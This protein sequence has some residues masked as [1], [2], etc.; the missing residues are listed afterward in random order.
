MYAAKVIL[1]AA[2]AALAALA[3][4]CTISGMPVSPYGREAT[5][6]GQRDRVTG[7]LIALTPD[8]IWLLSGQAVQPHTGRFQRID[9]RRHNFGLRRTMT[10]LGWAGAGTGT[11]LMIA[12]NSYESSAEGSGDGDCAA[13][14][15]GT[16]L[17]FA[18]A[19]VIFGSINEYTSRHRLRA[20]DTLRLRAFT[21][22]PQGLPDSLRMLRA[23]SA[24]T[25]RH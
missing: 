5:L 24:P 1:I 6:V 7:E 23:A 2:L 10:W 13:V 16:V 22:Y 15:P 8:T 17:F 25:A 18:A 14:L 9:V 19:G 21:R 12:C 4:G 20:S 11:A 3:S